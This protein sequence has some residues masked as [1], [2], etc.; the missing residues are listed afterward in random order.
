MIP[1]AG[2]T[3]IKTRTSKC[4]LIVLK[5]VLNPLGFLK[6]NVINPLAG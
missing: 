2:R 1:S 3:E 4:I 6:F 5:N